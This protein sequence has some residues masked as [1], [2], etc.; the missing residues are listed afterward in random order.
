MNHLAHFHLSQGDNGWMIGGLLGDF[1]KGPL[2]GN[3]PQSWEQGIQLHRRIDAFSDQHPEWRQCQRLFQPAFRR[4]GAIMLDV[5]AD[6]FLCKH[7][8]QFHFRQLDDFCD[9]IYQLLNITL[10][11]P[12]NAQTLA[13][14]M[15]RHQSLQSYGQWPAVANAL[16]RIGK[17]LKR[18]NP[19]H[20]AEQELQQH[21]GEIEQR[22]LQFYPQLQTFAD[23]QRLLFSQLSSR[24]N[25]QER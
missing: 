6:H 19:L 11:L 14:N 18:E 7:W 5:A 16:S 22:F 15:I 1:V 12:A 2:Q 24:E 13:N 17:R 3:Y 20:L 25:D 4:Y 23:E 9:E 8:Q 10:T 21:Y